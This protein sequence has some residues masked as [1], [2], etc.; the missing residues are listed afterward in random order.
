MDVNTP[1]VVPVD[2]TDGRFREIFSTQLSVTSTDVAPPDDSD[3]VSEN[4]N[5]RQV[6]FDEFEIYY[7]KVLDIQYRMAYYV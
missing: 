5:R 7:E 4:T 3:G 1:A 2:E 6:S